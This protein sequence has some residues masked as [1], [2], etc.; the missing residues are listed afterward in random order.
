MSDLINRDALVKRM[1]ERWRTLVALNGE[2]DHYTAGFDDAISYVDDAP[3]VDAVPVVHARW[4][5]DAERNT[6]C[7]RCETYIPVV[8]CYREYQD[9]ESEWDEEIEETEFCPNCGAK[10]D[11]GAK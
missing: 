4:V 5:K 1:S 11:G 3:A 7:S 2:Y 10:M 6:Y 9:Y 8:H